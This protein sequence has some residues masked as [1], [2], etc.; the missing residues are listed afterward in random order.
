MIDISKIRAELKKQGLPETL[1]EL[2][3]IESD[4]GLTPAITAIRA[5]TPSSLEDLSTRPGFEQLVGQIN[6]MKGIQSDFDRK[7]AEAVKT[8]ETNF[9][10]KN[11]ITSKD[12]GSPNPP[13]V[14]PL[15]ASLE[16]NSKV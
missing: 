11:T 12:D 6:S 7:V 5:L 2:L 1:A 4:E 16:K 15:M 14:N 8:F 13:S 10:T 3:N 9:R